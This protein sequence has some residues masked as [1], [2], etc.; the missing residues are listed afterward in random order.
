MESPGDKQDEN[1]I[2]Y[3]SESDKA[4]VDGLPQTLTTE[5]YVEIVKLLTKLEQSED[6]AEKS[7]YLEKLTQAKQ[8]VLKI[9]AEIDAINAEVKEKLYPFESISLKNKA[10]VDDIV[11]RY[12]ALSEYDQAKIDRWEDVIK[13]KTKIDN[14]LRGIIIGVVLA[15]IA[16]GITV[17]VVFRIRKRKRAKQLAMEELAAQYEDE[18]TE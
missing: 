17:V 6:F 3:F 15:V 16:G 8:D 4:A 18:D 1:P 9:Q 12:E 13:T 5:H 14:L 10:V 7:A 2:L 11:R